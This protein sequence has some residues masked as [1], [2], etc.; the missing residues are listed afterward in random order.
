[1][2]RCATI[3][4][5]GIVGLAA[6]WYG[7]SGEANYENQLPWLV[8]AIGSLVVSAFGIVGWLL[9]GIRGVHG[10]MHDVLAEIRTDRLGHDLVVPADPF[11]ENFPMV[12]TAAE[13]VEA[14]TYV[15][16]ASMTRVH[17]PDCQHV[18]G[19]VVEEI[20]VAEIERRG[21]TYCGVCC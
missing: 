11:T 9:A 10:E 15:T 8:G 21:L 18:Q 7:I 14:R 3:T 13:P 4:F 19:R 2:I 17:R 16:N 20:D 1:M 12:T 5:V 6:C